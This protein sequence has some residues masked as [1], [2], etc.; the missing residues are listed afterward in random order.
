M[1]SRTLLIGLDGATFTVLD[2][3]MADGVMP[4]LRDFVRR[5]ARAELMS[6]PN[7]LTPPAWTSLVTGRTP[8][9][10]GIFDFIRSSENDGGLYFT[11]NTSF[12]VRCETIW[13]AVGRLGG[14]ITSLNFPVTAPPRPVHGSVV[15]GFV[16]WRHLRR[17]V[18]PRELYDVLKSVPGFDAKELAM[19]MNEE[20]KS[21]QWL[22]EEQYE[23][24]ITHHIRRE[25]QWFGIA[26]AL[27]ASRPTDLVAVLF[28]GVDKLQHLFWRYL[29]PD[30]AP[31]LGSARE[32][33]VRDMCLE[34]FR[35]LDGVLAELLAAAGAETRVFF[36]SDH[37]FGPTSSVFY[38]N[39]WLER[40]GYLSWADG[41][42][43][44]DWGNFAADRVKSHVVG[45]DWS[46][47]RAYALTPSSNGIFIRKAARPG[48]PGVDPRDY[49][50][51]RRE[52][53]ARLLEFADPAT[54]RR[55]VRRVMTREE[56]FPGA[57]SENAPDLT[58]V[59]DDY[60]FLSVLNADTVVRQRPEPA[61]THRPQGI[62]L[63]GGPGI[64]P[65]RIEPLS[66]VDVAPALLF[67]L[68]LPVPADWEGR[69]PVEC[70]DKAFLG[71]HPVRIGDPSVPPDGAPAAGADR[72]SDEDEA[73]VLERLKALGYVE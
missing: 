36:A 19:D 38:A 20:L 12:D 28:D 21:I 57:A 47:T 3:L 61:G 68:G 2:P 31:T 52:L 9:N 33:R 39:V 25:R 13:S 69:V 23:A 62:F 11:L 6:T 29:D 72:M 32:G 41:T 66:I 51:F 14:T 46:R 67:S 7:P 8:G 59:L 55:I 10:H 24:W 27:L 56:A 17:S 58:L 65:G 22:P 71:S 64:A 15:P 54:G 49:D 48:L 18:H 53:A 16:P 1:M 34:Y 42:P 5:G 40:Q 26:R 60:G 70:F 30:L 37:G 63:A 4:C 35:R 50:S 43:K 45:I 73:K 44:D